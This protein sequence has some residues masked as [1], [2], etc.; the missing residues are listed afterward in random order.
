M[1][2]FDDLV[3]WNPFNWVKG[4]YRFAEQLTNQLEQLPGMMDDP[5]EFDKLYDD[6]FA[7][8]ITRPLLDWYKDRKIKDDARNYYDDLE[9]NTG[10]STDNSPYRWK[11]YYEKGL[12]RYSGYGGASE[13]FEASSSVVNQFNRRLYKW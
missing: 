1:S 7:G 10:Q 2:W 13:L 12:G 9:K 11:D 4:G 5:S 3:E 6:P 8:I